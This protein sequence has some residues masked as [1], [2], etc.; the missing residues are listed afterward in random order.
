MYIPSS[1]EVKEKESLYEFIEK[2]SFAIIFSQTENGPYATHVPLLLEREEGCLYGHMAKANPHWN[3][4]E[5]EVLVVFS[6][7][8]TYIS[9]S[10]YE[11]TLAVPTWNYVAVHA[12]G[13]L[14]LIEDPEELRRILDDS[15]NVYESTM[16][17]PWSMSSVDSTFISNLSKGII[18]FRIEIE[19]LEGKWKLSQ[20]HSRERQDRVIEALDSQGDE[21]SIQIAN[22]MKKNRNE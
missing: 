13:K 19:K 4:R 8:H 12:Y 10:W 5:N 15:V 2:N 1:F 11:T 7:P 18:G 21:N 3:S 17:N 20:N 6:G 14:E 9:P 16:P 22:L